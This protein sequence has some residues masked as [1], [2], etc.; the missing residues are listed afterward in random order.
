[1]QDKGAT[2]VVPTLRPQ[3]TDMQ[4][5]SG[6][7]LLMRN[8]SGCCTQTGCPWRDLPGEYG[9]RKTVYN[10]H[11]RSS[12]DGTWQ[13]VLGQATIDVASIRIWLPDPVL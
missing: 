13:K 3:D 5:R 10:R 6:M 11:R 9:N 12:L 8:G 7:T 2:M 1:M 4:L